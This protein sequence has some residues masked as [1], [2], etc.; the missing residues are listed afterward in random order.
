VTN[1]IYIKGDNVVTKKGCEGVNDDIM[2]MNI[3]HITSIEGGR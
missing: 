3:I 2:H 1:D